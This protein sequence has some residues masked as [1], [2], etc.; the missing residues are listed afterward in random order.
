MYSEKSSGSAKKLIPFF[1]KQHILV[2]KVSTCV[3]NLISGCSISYR[4]VT[5]GSPTA[6][7]VKKYKNSKPFSNQTMCVKLE[8]IINTQMTYLCS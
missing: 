3:C 6:N 5:L 7:S 2:I 1:L 4:G 8:D